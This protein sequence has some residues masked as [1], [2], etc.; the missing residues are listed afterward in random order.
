MLAAANR[1]TAVMNIA[2]LVSRLH[3]ILLGYVVA[4]LA[5][6]AIL[7]AANLSAWGS[8][9]DLT[10]MLWLSL[11]GFVIYAGVLTLPALVVLAITEI[12]CVRYLVAYLLL[13]ALGLLLPASYLGVIAAR[14]SVFAAIIAGAGI[15]AGLVYWSIAGRNAGA[16]RRLSLPK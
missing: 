5:A 8:T 14:N 16:A 6:G 11:Y 4:S 13:G 2:H 1:K 12:L 3:V 7:I 10:P 9:E 15:V